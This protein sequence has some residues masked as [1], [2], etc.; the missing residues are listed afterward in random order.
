VSAPLFEILGVAGKLL[1]VAFLLVAAV[2][3]MRLPDPFMRMHAATKAGTLGAG[4]V[5]IFTAIYMGDVG[6]KFT[7]VGILVFL[8]A[9]L[10]VAAHLL[11]RA[12]YVSG[13]AFDGAGMRDA[14]DGVLERQRLPLERRIKPAD[15]ASAPAAAPQAFAPQPA[16]APEP[17]PAREPAFDP[18]PAHRDR[19]ADLPALT[20][21]SEVT[22]P[23]IATLPEAAYRRTAAL[24]VDAGVP[25]TALATLDRQLVEQADRPAA[26]ESLAA[27]RAALD[28]LLAD[29]LGDHRYTVQY[30]ETDP[31][32]LAQTKLSGDGL[33]V[34]PQRGWFHHDVAL[35]SACFRRSSDR[36]L[37]FAVAAPARKLFLPADPVSVARVL[38]LDDGSVAAAAQLRWALAHRIWPEAE[39]LVV[40]QDGRG[41]SADRQAELA[42]AADAAGGEIRFARMGSLHDHAPA[43]EAICLPRLRPPYRTDWY[44]QFWL[45]RLA[46]GWRGELLVP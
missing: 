6:A 16:P 10:P 40:A 33:L 30:D 24:A 3:V 39:M 42:A 45:D 36:L 44:G 20:A 18:A 1:G 17:A 9:T 35:P 28:R 25:A 27:M 11:G 14:L 26:A 31:V 12:A 23:V 41:L 7:A 22:V 21:L 15:A 43:C 5:V 29:R 37:A 8:L 32:E 19:R 38:V 2:G 46:P 4:L 34:L 13:A